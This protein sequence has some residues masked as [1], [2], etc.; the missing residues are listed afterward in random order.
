MQAPESCGAF[1]LFFPPTLARNFVFN[2]LEYKCDILQYIYSITHPCLG[3]DCQMYDPYY[4][5]QGKISHL[6]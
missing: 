3:I 2:S 1:D 5:V 6:K 4:F